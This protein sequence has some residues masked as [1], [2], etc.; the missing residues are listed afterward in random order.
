MEKIT[1]E[2]IRKLQEGYNVTEIQKGIE[3]GDI[4]KLQGSAGRFA[5]SCLESGICFL[6]DK[7][8]NDYYGNPIPS[9]DIIE[10]GTKGSLENAQNFWQKVWEGDFEAIEYLEETF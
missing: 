3:S 9:R 6:G 1:V 7:V 8:T 10:K 4:W 5:M 2:E